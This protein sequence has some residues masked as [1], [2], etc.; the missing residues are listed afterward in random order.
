MLKESKKTKKKLGDILGAVEVTP[1][2]DHE[3][4]FNDYHIYLKEG[5][6]SPVPQMFLQNLV[7]SKVIDKLPE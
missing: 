3:I 5:V 2:K 4:H 1:K 7:T 6:S